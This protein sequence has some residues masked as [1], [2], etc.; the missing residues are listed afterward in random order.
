MEEII[1]NKSGMKKTI[2]ARAWERA[3]NRTKDASKDN[4]SS[5]EDEAEEIVL[6]SGEEQGDEEFINDGDLT[7]E[8]MEIEQQ[9]EDQFRIKNLLERAHKAKEQKSSTMFTTKSSNPR[10]FVRLL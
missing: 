6:G 2:T 1:I 4:L 3:L 5:S 7:R 9:E 8:R 10:L